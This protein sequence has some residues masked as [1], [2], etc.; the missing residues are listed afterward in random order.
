MAIVVCGIVLLPGCVFLD[1]YFP[2]KR[3]DYLSVEELP[4]LSVPDGLN[5]RNP[6]PLLP[7]PSLGTEPQ[8]LT[9]PVDAYPPTISELSSEIE[10]LRSGEEPKSERRR[11]WSSMWDR[12]SEPVSAEQ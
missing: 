4:P 7:I 5:V 8:N 11:W 2:D 6:D 3:L 12:E 9:E 10:A 1:E